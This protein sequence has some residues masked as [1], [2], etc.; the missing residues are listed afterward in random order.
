MIGSATG[1]V[2]LAMSP[3][4]FQPGQTCQDVEIPVTG[5]TTPATTASTSFRFAGSDPNNGVLGPDDYG[6]ITVFDP[7]VA[8]G[9]T[10]AP[11]VGV[12]GDPCAE[13]RA[14]SHPG[15]LKIAPRGSVTAGS[16]VTL[17][18]HG[19]RSGESVAF[20]LGGTPIGSAIADG[21]GDVTFTAQVPAGTPG[22]KNIFY[23]VGAGSGFTSTVTVNVRGGPGPRNGR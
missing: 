18:G 3:L 23:A 15:I 12:Q 13:F 20:T 14:L 16:V 4:T 21:D 10:P 7:N 6:K 22:G 17:T 5:S 19:Y 8:A 2:G 11:P 1:A 9:V